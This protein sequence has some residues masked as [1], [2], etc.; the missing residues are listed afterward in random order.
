[1]W[2]PS[3]ARLLFAEARTTSAAAEWKTVKWEPVGFAELFI[4][5]LQLETRDRSSPGLKRSM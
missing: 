1:M 4:I 2:L 3:V 5:Y